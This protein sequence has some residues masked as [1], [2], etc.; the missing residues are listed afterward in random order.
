MGAKIF[1][2]IDP[3]STTG[4]AIWYK[5]IKK[6]TITQYNGHC[7]AL[8]GI[9]KLID[10]EDISIFK[11]IIEDARLVKGNAYFAAKNNSK[12][13]QG[14]G[15]VKAYSKDWEIFCETMGLDYQMLPPNWKNTKATPEY[16]EQLTGIKTKK[17]HSHARD[18]GLIVFGL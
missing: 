13:D 18:A 7:Q 11:I 3:G 9:Q 8:L 5:G 10:G 6:L 14:V 16:F 1:I 2:G 15:A 17:T 12:K 4:V